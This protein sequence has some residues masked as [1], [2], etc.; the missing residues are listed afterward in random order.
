MEIVVSILLSNNFFPLPSTK[1]GI[2]TTIHQLEAITGTAIIAI[3]TTIRNE[4]RS[5]WFV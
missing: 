1:V 4:I 5:R 3:T 2:Q